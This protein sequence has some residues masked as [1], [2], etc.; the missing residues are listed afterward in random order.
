MAR[1]LTEAVLGPVPGP[2]EL[3]GLGLAECAALC[4]RIRR[5][6]IDSVGRTG[7][8]LGAN[9]STVELTM[10]LHRVFV[11]PETAIIWDTGHQC[12]THKILTGRQ[13]RFGD[14][15]A[16]GGLSG[17][18]SRA[19]SPHDLLENSHA[20]VGPAWAYGVAASTGRPAVVVLGDGALTGGVAYEGLNAIGYR[21]A[22]VVVVVND[23]GRSYAPTRSRLTYGEPID[24]PGHRGDG[25]ARAFFESLGFS[26]RGPVDGHDL[27]E[28]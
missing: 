8:H 18:P 26:Y 2:A 1:P 20:S 25:P 10:A 5:F 13:D 21:G 7:G 16:R 11:S 6:L 27:A 14:L 15:R 19:E 28:V 4:G 12:Y 3:R 17:F 22:P 9:L 24:V 23:N